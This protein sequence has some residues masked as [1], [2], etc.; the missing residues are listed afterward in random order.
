MKKDEKIGYLIDNH[1]GEWLKARQV[2]ENEISTKQQLICVCGRLATGFHEN[3]CRKFQGM[4]L[5]ETVKRLGHLI[6]R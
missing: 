5:S 6:K 1:F 3:T 2:V 4:V